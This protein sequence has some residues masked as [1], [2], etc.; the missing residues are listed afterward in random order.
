MFAGT[1]MVRV[2][3][4][5]LCFIVLL[6]DLAVEQTLCLVEENQSGNPTKNNRKKHCFL[7]S[8][9]VKRKLMIIHHLQDLNNEDISN[10][11]LPGVLKC[12]FLNPQLKNHRVSN[13]CH[14]S[15]D[16]GSCSIP[17]SMQNVSNSPTFR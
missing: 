7:E 4:L 6:V 3:T 13:D 11:P 5:T 1:N 10:L 15:P 2:S 9:P 16:L 14:Q 17:N 12:I 8:F